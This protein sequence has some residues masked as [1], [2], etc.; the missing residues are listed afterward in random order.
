MFVIVFLIFIMPK[1]KCSQGHEFLGKKFTVK[2]PVCGTDNFSLA[3]GKGP[4]EDGFVAKVIEF[5][6][7]YKYILIG[8]LVLILLIMF[9]KGC[10][11]DPEVTYD[12]RLNEYREYGYIIVN[13]KEYKD[14]TS[15]KI[16]FATSV[17]NKFN[18][19]LNGNPVIWDHQDTIYICEQGLYELKWTHPSSHPYND[20]LE[21]GG[22]CSRKNTSSNHKGSE[23]FDFSSIQNFYPICISDTTPPPPGTYITGNRYLKPNQS[24][25][26]TVKSNIK[27]RVLFYEWYKGKIGQGSII[28]KDSIINLQPDASSL[29]SVRVYYKENNKVYADSASI[30]VY[31]SKDIAQPIQDI[32]VHPTQIKATYINNKFIINYN[33]KLN[34]DKYTLN[35]QVSFGDSN[36]TN[37][38]NHKCL[39]TLEFP[40]TKGEFGYL[41]TLYNKTEENSYYFRF[42]LLFDNTDIIESEIYGPYQLVSCNQVDGCKLKKL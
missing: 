10:P 23:Q 17:Y 7:K 22:G 36:F 18:F 2:C 19:T 24:T 6:K 25:T 33:S 9:L 11:G 13:I 21:T 8:V 20:I 15:K 14:G 29:Y 26:L 40:S 37:N 16:P 39:S 1:Y 27:G 28:G 31:V 3:D 32:V 30:M 34:S 41:D 38:I 4:I 5:A 35:M 42:K 12:V